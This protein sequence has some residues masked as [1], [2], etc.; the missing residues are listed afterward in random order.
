MRKKPKL[1]T[2]LFTLVITDASTKMPGKA[3]HNLPYKSSATF[4]A[5]WDNMPEK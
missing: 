5:E 4:V 1:F 2:S 3:I